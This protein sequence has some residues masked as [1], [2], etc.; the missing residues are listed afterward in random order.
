MNRLRHNKASEWI[1]YTVTA[2]MPSLWYR[3]RYL[4]MDVCTYNGKIICRCRD[5]MVGIVEWASL[6]LHTILICSLCRYEGLVIM[7]RNIRTPASHVCFISSHYN[8]YANGNVCLTAVSFT[9]TINIHETDLYLI[10][11][12]HT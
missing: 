6:I 8:D 1:D 5:T 9:N 12:T 7:R 3:D 10:C 11:Y 2:A 4:S